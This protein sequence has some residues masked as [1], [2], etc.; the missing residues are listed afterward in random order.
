M[1]RY[2]IAL[3]VVGLQAWAGALALAQNTDPIATGTV[4]G[5]TSNAGK[6]REKQFYT[7]LIHMAWPDAGTEPGATVAFGAMDN[8]DIVW[9]AQTDYRPTLQ[10]AMVRREFTTRTPPLTQAQTPR[11]LMVCAWHLDAQRKPVGSPTVA[12]SER[13]DS[14]TVV[15]KPAREQ[16]SI[17]VRWVAVPAQRVRDKFP[18]KDYCADVQRGQP[19]AAPRWMVD[20]LPKQ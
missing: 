18:R 10:P 15:G 17:N 20:A 13:N 19:S 6:Q 2:K 8:G 12:Y 9:L 14:G 16:D 5:F 4:S 3:L 7:I 11:Y 1:R